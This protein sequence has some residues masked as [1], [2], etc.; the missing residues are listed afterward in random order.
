MI[1]GYLQAIKPYH[2]PP[3]PCPK[4]GEFHL[5]KTFSED[6]ISPAITL[7]HLKQKTKK[8]WASF[9]TQIYQLSTK[10][11]YKYIHKN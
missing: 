10:Y 1:K 6:S 4:L 11:K 7:I 9:G 3:P 5:Y 8:N 2:T